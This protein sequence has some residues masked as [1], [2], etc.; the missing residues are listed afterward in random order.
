MSCYI[1]TDSGGYMVGPKSGPVALTKAI[2][3]FRKVNG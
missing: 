2:F 3:E 1:W